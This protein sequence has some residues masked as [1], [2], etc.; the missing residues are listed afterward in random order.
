MTVCWVCASLGLSLKA[1]CVRLLS[2]TTM[3]RAGIICQCLS[4]TEVMT[5]LYV[6][7]NGLVCNQFV[8]CLPLP[9]PREWVDLESQT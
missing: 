2:V 4:H 9:L 8:L 3:Y 5:H 7:G 1:V 6:L